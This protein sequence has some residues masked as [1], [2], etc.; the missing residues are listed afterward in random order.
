MIIKKFKFV[1]FG[2]VDCNRI[3]YVNSDKFALHL[4]EF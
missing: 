4:S 1:I 3:C 2:V